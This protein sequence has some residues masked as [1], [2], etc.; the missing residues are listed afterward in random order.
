MVNISYNQGVTYSLGWK[1]LDEKTF[2]RLQSESQKVADAIKPIYDEFRERLF[3]ATGQL[4]ANE[5][6][7]YKDTIADIKKMAPAMMWKASSPDGRRQQETVIPNGLFFADFDGIGNPKRLYNERLAGRETALGILYG[8]GSLSELG[9]HVVGIIPEGLTHATAMQWIANIVGM[10]FDPQ[11]KDINRATF[12][13]PSEYTYYINKEVLWGEA[14]AVSP[15]SLTAAEIADIEARYA[16]ANN[17][18]S[19]RTKKHPHTTNPQGNASTESTT[20]T[21]ATTDVSYPAEYHGV[22]YQRIVE[23]YFSEAVPQPGERNASLHKVACDLRSVCDNTPVWIAQVVTPYFAKL[24]LTDS[25]ILHTVQSACKSTYYRQ[26]RK[27]TEVLDRLLGKERGTSLQ[28]LHFEALPKLPKVL[29]ALLTALACKVPYRFR[30]HVIRA[31][32]SALCS[33][34]AK[35]LLRSWDNAPHYTPF[36]HLTV[37]GYSSGKDLVN[38]PIKAIWRVSGLEARDAEARQRVE[39][40]KKNGCTYGERPEQVV[41]KVHSNMTSAAY[42]DY[43]AHSDGHYLYCN[44][45]ELFDLNGLQ[46]AD[47]KCMVPNLIKLNFDFA[48]ES[49]AERIGAE[50]V[51]GEYTVQFN[52]N[53]SCTP[54]DLLRFF[55]NN[56]SDGTPTRLNLST[57]PPSK[58]GEPRPAIGTYDDAYDEALR[59]YIDRIIAASYTELDCSVVN[60]FMRRLEAEIKE[61]AIERGDRLWDVLTHRELISTFIQGC[62]LYVADG[63][64]WSKV[65]ENYL[66]WTT[67]YGLGCKMMFLGDAMRTSDAKTRI[68]EFRAQ[69]TDCLSQLDDTFKLDEV[70]AL[71]QT[72]N[73]NYTRKD[74][75]TYMR[76]LISRGKIIRTNEKDWF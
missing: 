69:P 19:K 20:T 65:I 5:L 6:K 40:W 27:M 11:T 15:V 36:V 34:P 73:P 26:S 67:F 10:S 48:A 37:G 35:L 56:L 12:V 13:S 52:I 43:Q 53:T 68:S 41:Q 4:V 72:V 63:M 30:A 7:S 76:Q 61:E 17:G 66:R 31:C 3:D 45:N 59:P 8:G 14:E 58:I 28:E 54:Y 39:E 9:V 42:V 38:E 62:I 64:K 23:E 16:A 55:R 18:D 25:E 32:F 2:E 22:P 51:T 74:A 70:I 71:R 60:R 24:G 29:P 21:A 33:L 1:S 47:R 49:G 75:L 46:G 57:T 44:T 50:S